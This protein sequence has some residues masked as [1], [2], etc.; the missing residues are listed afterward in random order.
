[1]P[2]YLTSRYASSVVDFV[3]VNQSTA[4]YPVIFYEFSSIGKI[5]YSEY[6]WKD[7]DRLDQL[8][9]NQYMD[10]ER[11]WIIMEYNPEIVD[12]HNIKPGTVLRIPSV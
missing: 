6:T 4:A 8:A 1:M 5:T 11:W 12:P 2:I 7:G 9:M 10:P 3:S